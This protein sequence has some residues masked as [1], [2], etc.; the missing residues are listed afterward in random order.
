MDSTHTT[1]LDLGIIKLYSVA[2][3]MIIVIKQI[4]LI[5]CMMSAY[6]IIGQA[7]LVR[8]W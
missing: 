8:N 6:N 4:V 3:K 5:S 1:R 7:T 2:T